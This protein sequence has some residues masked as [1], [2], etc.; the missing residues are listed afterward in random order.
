MNRIYPTRFALRG[1]GFS[2]IEVLISVLILGLGLLGVAA[3]QAT[4]LRNN[5]SAAERSEATVLTYAMLDSMR[6]NRDDANNGSYNLTSWTCT[7]P[8]TGTELFQKDLNRWIT[9]VQANLGDTACGQINCGT[10]L[11][12]IGVR[13]DDARGLGGASAQEVFTRTRL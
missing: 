11:C 7:A 8:A 5:Q 4:A 3:M 6:A 12:V 1:R 13:W 10:T 9:T 2:L